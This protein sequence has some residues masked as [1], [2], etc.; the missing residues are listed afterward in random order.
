LIHFHSNFGY[1]RFQTDFIG[2]LYSHPKKAI[3]VG[4]VAWLYFDRGSFHLSWSGLKVRRLFEQSRWTKMVSTERKKKWTSIFSSTNILWAKKDEPQ[5]YE[6]I[7]CLT[8]V[9]RL[10]ELR[11]PTIIKVV[12]VDPWTIQ[13]DY[14]WNTT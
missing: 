9:R 4:N 3:K 10:F 12:I 8:M 7:L 14:L 13:I 2:P 1:E 5:S 6:M 11:T